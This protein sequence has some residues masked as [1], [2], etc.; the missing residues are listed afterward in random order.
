MNFVETE[1]EERDDPDTPAEEEH[2]ASASD[3]A[4]SAGNGS[5][6]NGND[7][8]MVRV[9]M[10]HFEKMARAHGTIKLLNTIHRGSQPNV[11][12]IRAAGQVLLEWTGDAIVAFECHPD[13]L[14]TID[15]YEYIV[16]ALQQQHKQPA[17]ASVAPI[18][19]LP[20]ALLQKV[21]DTLKTLEFLNE[22]AQNVLK[23]L[24]NIKVRTAQLMCDFD[25][26]NT[27]T[28]NNPSFYWLTR[29]RLDEIATL[30][31][32]VASLMLHFK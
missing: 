31:D 20:L 8:F 3:H 2:D 12:A 22:P 32:F 6:N 30:F 21:G 19:K 16:C 28:H 24:L 15:A 14:C 4:D 23:A 27:L 5:M 29:K 17:A 1:A 11:T 25:E 26:Q 7:D 9:V 13:R 10:P 18:Y